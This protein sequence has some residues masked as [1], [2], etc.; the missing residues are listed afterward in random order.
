MGIIKL[1]LNKEP[2]DLN[3]QNNS[4]KLSAGQRKIM[5]FDNEVK[6]LIITNDIQKDSCI[7][8]RLFQSVSYDLI[9]QESFSVTN[10]VI[11]FTDL[12]L[13]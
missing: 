8:H 7:L 3:P 11:L 6:E 13:L 9:P 4:R 12:R 1:T 5:Y 2:K 10:S